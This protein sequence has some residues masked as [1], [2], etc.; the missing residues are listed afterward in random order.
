MPIKQF[1]LKLKLR[2]RERERESV[3]VFEHRDSCARS[4]PKPEYT[5]QSK[6]EL[7]RKT[8]I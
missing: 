4:Q 3:C 6:I 5:F 1:K 8:E 7:D 2:E